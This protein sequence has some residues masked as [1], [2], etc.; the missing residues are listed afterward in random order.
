[1][2]AITTP[3]EVA[4]LLRAIDGFRGTFIVKSALLLA[5]LLFVRPG[6]L[7]RAEWAGFDLDKAEW[8]YIV[9]KSRT[10]HRVPLRL[11]LSRSCASC[12]R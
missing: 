9:T 4:E 8:R 7:R 10:E 6:E 2:T 1:M 3:K 11:Q 5:P 12:K